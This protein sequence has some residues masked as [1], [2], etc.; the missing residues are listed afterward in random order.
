MSFVEIGEIESI[1]KREKNVSLMDAPQAKGDR[2]YY[3]ETRLLKFCPKCGM[4]R[5]TVQTVDR[6]KDV[7][8]RWYGVI[9][10]Y[11]KVCSKLLNSESVPMA[12]LGR[13]G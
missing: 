2:N 8:H 12:R 4:V 5:K 7:Y 3:Q 1:H 9:N 10:H 13:N 11:C 6:R